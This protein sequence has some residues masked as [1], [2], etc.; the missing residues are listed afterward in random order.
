MTTS[1]AL[2]TQEMLV[3]TASQAATVRTFRWP[4]DQI[5]PLPLISGEEVL[6]MG[7]LDEPLYRTAPISGDPIPNN[8]EC[9]GDWLYMDLA[10][11]IVNTNEYV[12]DPIW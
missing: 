12:P 8:R 9:V 10:R 7:F 11:R 1:N 4:T 5:D 6:T 3:L 2:S